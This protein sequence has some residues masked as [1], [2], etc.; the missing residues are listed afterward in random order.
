M[1]FDEVRLALVLGDL[2]GNATS[3]RSYRQIAGG[4]IEV[5]GESEATTVPV[6]QFAPLTSEGAYEF[7][8][9][10]VNADGEVLRATEFS[11]QCRPRSCETDAPQMKSPGDWWL[12]RPVNRIRSH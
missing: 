1:A 10:G 9:V 3:I 4:H 6:Y 5:A 2:P 12:A 7:W 8:L 11:T